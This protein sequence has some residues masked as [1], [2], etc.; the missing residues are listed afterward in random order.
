MV[1]TLLAD[2]RL[3]MFGGL[4]SRA[5]LEDER[6]TESLLDCFASEPDEERQLG[7]FHQL[8][9]RR[10]NTR[11]VDLLSAW[12]QEHASVLIAEQR[13][14]FAGTDVIERL[15]HR[16][17]ASEYAQK[18]WIYLY[19]AHALEDPLLIR[20]FV[21]KHTDSSDPRMVQAAEVSLAILVN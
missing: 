19:S 17:T 6:I 4:L 5:N 20:A 21:T 11:R 12:A 7:L 16:M 14:F 2:E 1:L 15:E 18:R 13:A 10:L 9:A 8:V 3:R